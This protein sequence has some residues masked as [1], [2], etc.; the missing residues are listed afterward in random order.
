MVL[1]NIRIFERFKEEVNKPYYND[2]LADDVCLER[3]L[4]IIKTIEE[5]NIALEDSIMFV[6]Y[7]NTCQ[8]AISCKEYEVAELMII[9]ASDYVTL[10]TNVANLMWRESDLLFEMGE[11]D[12]S[13]AEY[14]RTVKFY[15]EAHKN[16]PDYEPYLAK[17]NICSIKY[18]IATKF[19]DE[20][21]MLECMLETINLYKDGI[22]SSSDLELTYDEFKRIVSDIQKIRDIKNSLKL[23][24]IVL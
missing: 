14:V 12:R 10:D 4:E 17:D 19:N 13:Y 3:A 7:N 11:L 15:E 2:L 20:N 1:N 24:K 16:N 8:I 6:I 23:N 22:Y 18:N 9:K 5:N 21:Y